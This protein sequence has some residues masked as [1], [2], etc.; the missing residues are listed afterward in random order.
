MKTKSFAKK[1]NTGFTLIELLVVIAIIGILS[2]VVLS[3]LGVARTKGSDAVVKAGM[4]QI[5]NQA[6]IYYD[7]HN[8]TYGPGITDC[9]D[10]NG[11]F[12]VASNIIDNI[13]LQAS[14]TSPTPKCSTNAEG[15]SWA[16]SAD[17]RGGGKWCV[18]SSG[19]VG[20]VDVDATNGACQTK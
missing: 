16:I 11:I 15:S 5:R 7:S 6:A 17:L 20:A 2:S 8:N 18:D 13:K 9:Y 1:I 4:N 12:S 3:S 19:S 14:S 10:P